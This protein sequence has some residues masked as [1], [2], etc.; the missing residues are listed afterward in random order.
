MNKKDFK[1]YNTEV[2]LQILKK[3]E[4]EL[5]KAEAENDREK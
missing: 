2:M 5:Q 3:S 1:D 4:V